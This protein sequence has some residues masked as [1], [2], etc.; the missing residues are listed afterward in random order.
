MLSPIKIEKCCKWR[1]D[2]R[3]KQ[4]SVGKINKKLFHGVGPLVGDRGPH[5]G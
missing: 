2:A 3:G 5:F 1:A 4:R